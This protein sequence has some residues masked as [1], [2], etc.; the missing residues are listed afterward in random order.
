MKII[1]EN[2]RKLQ[3]SVL[4][5]LLGFYRAATKRKSKQTPIGPKTK[6]GLKICCLK[7][8]SNTNL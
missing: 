3:P 1:S 5:D 8:L 6:I 2:S 7:I 4:I